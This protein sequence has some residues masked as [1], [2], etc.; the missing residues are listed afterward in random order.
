MPQQATGTKVATVEVEIDYAILEHFSKHLYSSP[1]KAVEELVTN[2]Y[3]ALAREVHVY[4][5]GSMAEDCLLVWDDGE[6]MDVTGLQ[7]LWWI[8]RSPKD[9]GERVATS[10]DGKITR[11]MIGKFGIGKLA[12]YA[13]GQRVSH[14]CRRGDEFLLVTVDYDKAP[15]IE[16]QAKNGTRGFATPVLELD[17]DTARD[18]ARGLFRNV[19]GAFDKLW[20][21][22]HWTLAVV[23][24]LRPDVDLKEGRLSWVLG[25]GMPLRPD[26]TVYVNDSKVAP[27]VEQGAVV[28]WNLGSKELQA[29][30]KSQ[31]A[32]AAKGGVVSGEVSFTKK[33]G[34]PVATFPNLGQVTARLRLFDRSLRE[35]RQAAHGRSEGF[36]VMVRDRLLN[37]D[38]AK[39]LLPDPSFGTFNRMHATISS[40]G[41]DA[42]LLADRERLHRAGPRA[43]E[44]AV[45]Q[46]AMYLAARSKIDKMDD[47]KSKKATPSE[48]LP[49]S[50]REFY[51]QPLTAFALR[52]QQDGTPA[53]DPSNTHIERAVGDATEPLLSIDTA[54][55]RL[56]VNSSHPLFAAVHA[57]V[58][59]TK[60]GREALRLVELLAV[61]DTLLEGHLADIGMDDDVIDRVMAWRDAQLR[62]MAVRYETAPEDVIAEAR[63]ASYKGQARFEK[64]LAR[65]FAMMGFLA[66]RD[67][68]SG[69]KDVLVVA[70]V[71]ADEFRFT[72]EGKGSIGRV[73]ND[74]A[75]ISGAAAHAKA[76]GASFA[77]VVAREFVGFERTGAEEPAVLQ[78]CRTSEPPVTVMDLDTL[79]ALYEA[80]RRNHYPL[81]ELVPVLRE[82]E[83]PSEK[84]ASVEQIRNPVEKFDF[85]GLL[86]LIWDLQQRAASRDAVSILQL[87]QSRPVWKALARE[88]FDRIVYALEAMSRG[89][90]VRHS[91]SFGVN[92]LQSP[93]IVVDCILEALGGE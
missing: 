28:D 86:E 48:V 53:L 64:A 25:N 39:L 22:Q 27:K 61:S 70:P 47:E 85:R 4:L 55:G 84:R 92:L 57:K 50:S 41:L 31:W 29:A 54:G 43:A 15:T 78:E 74:D 20:G 45:L 3:D 33:G 63:E 5:P 42:E 35:G 6:S 90:L 21:R 76:V 14:L 93:D 81:T 13:V 12:S 79:I 24:T 89:L 23:D 34:A 60:K 1:N 46:Q 8:A 58:G 91:E 67:G 59:D 7:R 37:P 9:Q 30:V 16:Q 18:Y 69:V 65:L 11:R 2:G 17:E 32:E 68:A 72:V 80:L 73:A 51:R 87:R 49:S 52:H 83:S 36:F 38:D 62:A 71:G 88:D 40:D 19:P 26:F 66:E 56:V 44:L 82:I 10:A 75:E 77:V